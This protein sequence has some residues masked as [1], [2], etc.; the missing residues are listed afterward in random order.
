MY[1]VQTICQSPA[2]DKQV[3][4]NNGPFFQ[5]VYFL[6][7][8][9]REGK[10]QW[11]KNSKIIILHIK[12]RWLWEKQSMIKRW[13]V[14]KVG[15]G[16]KKMV[17]EGF[18]GLMMFNQKPECWEEASQA[19]KKVR[20]RLSINKCYLSTHV[21]SGFHAWGTSRSEAGGQWLLVGGWSWVPRNRCWKDLVHHRKVC[22]IWS[23]EDFLHF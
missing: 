14:T 20:E 17:R 4:I 3:N 23:S 5:G 22:Y 11:F 15:R 21:G 8:E 10:D 19:K 2:L 12:R 18:S 6:V 13:R 1:G 9:R 7:L 16:T